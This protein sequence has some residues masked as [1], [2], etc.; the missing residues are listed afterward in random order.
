MVQNRETDKTDSSHRRLTGVGRN[1]KGT[2]RNG[3]PNQKD[4]DSQSQ[5]LAVNYKDSINSNQ[6]GSDNGK[7]T[8]LDDLLQ[9]ENHSGG[10]RHNK[11]D[12]AR[13]NGS[14]GVGL[15][16]DASLEKYVPA[17]GVKQPGGLSVNG[18][19]SLETDPEPMVE[20]PNGQ[21]CSANPTDEQLCIACARIKGAT[22]GKLPNRGRTRLDPTCDHG[23]EN[24][25][26]SIDGVC[27]YGKPSSGE[28]NPSSKID[29]SQDGSHQGI[30]EV[31]GDYQAFDNSVPRKDGVEDGVDGSMEVEGN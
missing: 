19:R 1:S 10:R 30:P 26:G 24:A 23:E 29:D 25:S 2:G 13:S 5:K 21:T 7:N 15:R 18:G 3:K 17:D 4:K 9:G 22:F 16:T 14:M 27:D 28:A 6:W 31:V 8:Q 11:V 20:I 12:K